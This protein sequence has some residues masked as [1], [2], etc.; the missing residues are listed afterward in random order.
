[1]VKTEAHEHLSLEACNYAKSQGGNTSKQE[2]EQQ[3]PK[4]AQKICSQHAYP[5]RRLKK[6]SVEEEKNE[7][8]HVMTCS[9]EK[10]L[11]QSSKKVRNKQHEPE[12]IQKVP[13]TGCKSKDSKFVASQKQ[14][15]NGRKQRARKK[16]FAV[17]CQ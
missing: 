9:H 8:F 10:L 4:S 14:Q 17:M 13:V 2:D 5:L 3:K 1:L 7:P 16:E 15:I 6:D 12:N 11:D